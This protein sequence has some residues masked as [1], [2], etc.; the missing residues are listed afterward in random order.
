MCDVT[1]HYQPVERRL[2]ITRKCLAAAVEFRNP[3]SR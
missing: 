1:G 2:R 3:L